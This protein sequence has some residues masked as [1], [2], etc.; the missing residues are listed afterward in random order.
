MFGKRPVPGEETPA[1]PPPRPPKPPRG[2]ALGG[3]LSTLVIVAAILYVSALIIS[4]TAGFRT[5]T[6][7]KLAESLDGDVAL[8]DAHP[9]L[10]LDLVLDG[11][12]NGT[13]DTPGTA[14]LRAERVRLGWSFLRRPGCGRLR[15][16][17]FEK[18]RISFAQSG[19]GSWKPEVLSKAA[20]WLDEG[21]AF[22]SQALALPTR[23]ARTPAPPGG[24]EATAAPEKAPEKKEAPSADAGD[25][26]GREVAFSGLD[27]VWWDAASNRMAIVRGLQATV[28]PVTVPGRRLVHVAMHADS[29]DRERGP[30]MRNASLELILSG[31]EKFL[32]DL[33]LGGG[34]TNAPPDVEPGPEA[35]AAP[36]KTAPPVETP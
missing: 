4:H 23:A 28:T 3:C 9:T 29:L 11:L 13:P 22:A 35:P 5:F 12:T 25:W 6:A 27:V 31:K 36:A 34:A 10:R 30:S 17:E 19:D 26:N 18:G 16:L 15:R 24:A 33:R 21:T 8:R 14:G 1:P 7:R 2:D 32:L 20:A